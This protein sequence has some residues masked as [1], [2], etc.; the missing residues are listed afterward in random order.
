MFE[1]GDATIP[2]TANAV[3]LTQG[4]SNYLVRCL[5]IDPPLDWCNLGYFSRVCNFLCIF[6]EAGLLYTCFSCK[7]PNYSFVLEGIHITVSF[8]WIQSQLMERSNILQFRVEFGMIALEWFLLKFW[9]YTINVWGCKHEWWWC[10]WLAWFVV[11][12]RP[13]S[14]NTSPSQ[15]IRNMNWCFTTTSPPIQT[16][17]GMASKHLGVGLLLSSYINYALSSHTYC[18]NSLSWKFNHLSM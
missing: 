2:H 12:V 9:N 18:R 13:A 1:W 8:K 6:G 17:M 11:A 15:M 5:A 10:C 3:Q 14:L 16:K 4:I 7:R